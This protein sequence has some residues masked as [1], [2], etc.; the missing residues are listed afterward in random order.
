MFTSIAAGVGH[1]LSS[2]ISI[3]MIPIYYK[4]VLYLFVWFV[5]TKFTTGDPVHTASMTPD[6]LCI[7]MCGYSALFS[8]MCQPLHSIVNEEQY[9]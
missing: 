9:D 1:F 4:Y 3:S 2:I 8:V 5:V 6:I 7:G